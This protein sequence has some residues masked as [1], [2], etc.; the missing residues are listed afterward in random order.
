MNMPLLAEGPFADD[1]YPFSLTRSVADI[2][3]GILTLREKWHFHAKNNPELP[4]GISVSA[5]VI[6]DASLFRSLISE[7]SDASFYRGQQIG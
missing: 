3:C 5:N 6:P 7:F 2:R 1:F 4:A